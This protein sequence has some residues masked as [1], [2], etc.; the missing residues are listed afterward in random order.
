MDNLDL[1]H[2]YSVGYF[3]IRAEPTRWPD[4][5]V[6]NRPDK[7]ISLSRCF[8]TYLRFTWTWSDDTKPEALAFGIPESLFDDC[9]QWC[10]DKF[11]NEI[12]I[13]G[14]FYTPDIAQQFMK[15]FLVGVEDLHIV[16]VGLAHQ[17]EQT[18]WQITLG[19]GE[20]HG[21]EAQIARH[22][23]MHSGGKF[24]GFDIASYDGYDF[25][26]SWL[27]G[28]VDKDMRELFGIQIDKYGLLQTEREAKQVYYW[29]A[30]DKMQGGRGEPEPYYYWLLM[31][32][33]EEG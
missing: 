28:S 24:L 29:I 17:V 30:E 9:V 33:T 32:Y 31:D 16:G 11:K 23:P 10:N 27:C 4:F 3:I 7:Y 12:D 6:D 25:N 5:K 26:H 20:L 18:Y 2:F 15:R 1:Q 21:I 19:H 14:V 8:G 13:W 22:L